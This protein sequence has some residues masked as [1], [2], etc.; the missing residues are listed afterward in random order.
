MLSALGSDTHL[1]TRKDAVLRNFDKTI[2]DAITETIDNGPTVLHK[3]T[4]V[5]VQILPKYRCI[6]DSDWEVWIDFFSDLLQELS[7][8]IAGPAFPVETDV[9]SS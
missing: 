8:Q 7:F 4:E 2:S 6:C 1:L 5:Y 9:D 3:H